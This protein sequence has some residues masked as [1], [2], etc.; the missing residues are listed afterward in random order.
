MGQIHTTSFTKQ[1]GRFG[2]NYMYE[3]HWCTEKDNVHV[4]SMGSSGKISVGRKRGPP[5]QVG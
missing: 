4:C 2:K 5:T 1:S 3:D